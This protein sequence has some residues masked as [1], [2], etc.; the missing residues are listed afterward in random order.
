MLAAEFAAYVDEV[1][2]DAPVTN[3]GQRLTTCRIG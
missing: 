1:I 3:V 2:R